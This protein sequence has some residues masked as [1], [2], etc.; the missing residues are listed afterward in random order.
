MHSFTP[1]VP[2]DWMHKL[3]FVNRHQQAIFV[4]GFSKKKNSNQLHMFHSMPRIKWER[5][6]NALNVRELDKRWRKTRKLEIFSHHYFYSLTSEKECTREK[7]YEKKNTTAWDC[8]SIVWCWLT[9]KARLNFKFESK[10]TVYTERSDFFRFSISTLPEEKRK[11]LQS[12]FIFETTRFIATRF[13]LFTLISISIN[14]LI[15]RRNNKTTSIVLLNEKIPITY[16]RNHYA[17]SSSSSNSI[18]AIK[19]NRA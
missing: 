3:L 10:F 7:V 11:V 16:S 19:R 18:Y 2:V 8:V 14:E 9:S 15:S 13:Y 1:C 17:R 12:Q 6:K 5:E 4:F